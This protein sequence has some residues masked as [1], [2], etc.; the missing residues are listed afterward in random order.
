VSRGCY[1]GTAR[2]VLDPGRVEGFRPGDVLV[3]TTTDPGWAPLFSLAGAMVVDV[4]GM[5][6]HSAIIARELRV[7]AV[8]NTQDGTKGIPDGARVRV[9]GSTGE[10]VVEESGNVA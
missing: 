4:G 1:T 6:S 9:D 3:C 7:P 10:V 5:L 2:V 8:V